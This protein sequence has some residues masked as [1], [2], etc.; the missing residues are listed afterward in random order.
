M[1]Q[2]VHSFRG[3]AASWGVVPWWWHL[4]RHTCT[5]INIIKYRYRCKYA[6]K[7][8]HKYETIHMCIYIYMYMYICMCL[9]FY[10]YH[11][12]YCMYT[13]WALDLGELN[14]TP[15]LVALMFEHTHVWDGLLT[16]LFLHP[17]RD[18]LSL[19][20]YQLSWLVCSRWNFGH[21]AVD[22][23]SLFGAVFFANQRLKSACIF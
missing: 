5:H 21:T 3:C 6:C 7:Y 2:A 19:F 20:T 1:T 4:G 10:N 16:H 13:Y 18:V 22:S 9:L 23:I 15:P 14:D 17:A 11:L 8:K 12:S